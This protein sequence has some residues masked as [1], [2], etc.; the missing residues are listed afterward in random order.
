M[1]LPLLAEEQ[2]L[3]PAAE[4]LRRSAL[5]NGL[6]RRTVSS[7]KLERVRNEERNARWV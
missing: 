2:V 3:R 7:S 1:D 6:E 4:V 5:R